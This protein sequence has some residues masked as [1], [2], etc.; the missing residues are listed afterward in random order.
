M[1]QLKVHIKKRQ[2]LIEAMIAIGKNEAYA[3]GYVDAW[4]NR[5]NRS[6]SGMHYLKAYSECWLAVRNNGER[7][8]FLWNHDKQFESLKWRKNYVT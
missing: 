5:D 4:L 7:N 3:A 2:Y 6:D 8:H 1:D